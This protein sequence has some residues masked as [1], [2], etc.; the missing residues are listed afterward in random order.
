MTIPIQPGPVILS[1]YD[2]TNLANILYSSSVNAARDYAGL[3][4]NQPVP[5][6]ANGRVYVGAVGQLNVFGLLGVTPTVPA[7]VI[8]PASGSVAFPQ[9]VSISDTFG[10]ATIYYTTDGS[11]SQPRIQQ[12]YRRSFTWSHHQCNDYRDRQ[13]NGLCAEYANV[14]DLHIVRR[15][16]GLSLRCFLWPAGPTRECRP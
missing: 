1:A 4:T 6:V 5:T 10:G 2:A 3:P 13:C 7:P 16:S 12:V 14:G 11:T 8:T 9:T 15:H